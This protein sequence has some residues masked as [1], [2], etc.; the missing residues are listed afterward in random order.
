MKEKGVLP[1]HLRFQV[2]MPMVNSA[3][4]PRVFPVEGDLDKIKPGFEAALRAELAKIVEEIPAEN[5]PSSGTAR[6]K[7]RTPMARFRSCRGRA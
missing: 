1:P 4:P 6:P 5:S 7:C 3:L 2:S